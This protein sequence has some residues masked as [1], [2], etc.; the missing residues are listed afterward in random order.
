MASRIPSDFCADFAAGVLA[1]DGRNGIVIIDNFIVALISTRDFDFIQ[2]E[3]RALRPRSKWSEPISFF[4][5]VCQVDH[6]PIGNWQSGSRA[7]EAPMN[8]K[9]ENSGFEAS[10]MAKSLSV[11]SGFWTSLDHQRWNPC[12]NIV[13]LRPLD[14]D[15]V[16]TQY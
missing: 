15:F 16:Q 7:P 3:I 12:T 10:K 1:D 11:D 14:S 5:I 8:V 2:A 6:G 13:D 9:P 4:E